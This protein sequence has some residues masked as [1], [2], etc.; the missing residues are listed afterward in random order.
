[1]GLEGQVAASSRGERHTRLGGPLI[2]S[3]GALKAFPVVTGLS[4]PGSRQGA[5]GD[6]QGRAL[7]QGQHAR[8]LTTA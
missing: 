8:P 4:R 3:R 5:K 7:S 6:R 1:M 2:N